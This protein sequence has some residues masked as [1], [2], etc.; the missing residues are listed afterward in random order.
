MRTVIT[1]A[2]IQQLQQLAKREARELFLWDDQQRGFGIRASRTGHVSY[3]VQKWNGKAVR[4]VLDHW[5]HVKLKDARKKAVVV[6]G[7]LYRPKVFPSLGLAASH[8][9]QTKPATQEPTTPPLQEAFNKY[10][11]KRS[12]P[13]KHWAEVNRAFNVDVLPFLGAETRLENITKQQIRQLISTKEVT[14]PSMARALDAKTRSFFSWCVDQD[15]LTVSPMGNLVRPEQG[16]DR[17]RYLT[18]A[19]IVTYWSATERQQY[20][21]RQFYQ[22]CLL[23]GQRNQNEVGPMCWSEISGNAWTVPKTRAKNKRE[24]IV[25]LPPLALKVL[26][27]IPKNGHDLVFTS[28]GVNPITSF[29]RA[30]HRMDDVMKIDDWQVHDL[31]RTL[32]THLASMKVDS[33]VAD[34]LLNHTPASKSGI[35]G[36]YQKFQFIDER[37]EAMMLWGRY[38]EK[39]ISGSNS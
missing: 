17:D 39:L 36:V 7:E 32:V 23:T 22:L 38:I 9:A 5:P 37:K 27:S 31:R 14:A 20:P 24:H 33:N 11:A 3:V 35:K 13:G 2:A 6:L 4:V 1:P 28:D 12:K 25:H 16:D 15:L 19:E 26:D 29:S 10:V 34:M 18:E 8:A 21:W 30:K